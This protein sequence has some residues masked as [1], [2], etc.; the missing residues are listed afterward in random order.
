[1]RG[2]RWVSE[3]RIPKTKTRIWLG[4]HHSPV[5]AARAYDAALYCL[6][7]EQGLFNFP[8]NRKPD[9]ANRSVGSLSIDEIQCIA[10]EF[11]SLDE[12]MATLEEPSPMLPLGEDE[13]HLSPEPLFLPDPKNMNE[14]GGNKVDGEPY[15]PNFVQDEE[16]YIP[17]YA[18]EE[19]SYIPAYAPEVVAA[20]MSNGNLQLDEWLT[21]DGDWM[22]NF[23]F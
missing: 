22:R 5:K 20:S 13:D 15:V 9:L 17:A 6:K 23:H 2:G 19:E 4:S 12:S 14:M 7:G 11:S 3:I 8:H 16:P 21:L 1:M 10:A 18:P